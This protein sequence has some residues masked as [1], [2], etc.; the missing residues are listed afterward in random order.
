MLLVVEVCVWREVKVVGVG[1]VASLFS[2]RAFVWGDVD[3]HGGGLGTGEPDG[4]A[5]VV[6]IRAPALLVC[7]GG[8]IRDAHACEGACEGVGSLTVG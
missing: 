6:K 7:L 8:G 3:P 2:A 5:V 4:S 1:N